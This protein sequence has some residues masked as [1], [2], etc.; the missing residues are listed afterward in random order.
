MKQLGIILI[1]VLWLSVAAHGQLGNP[2]KIF[3]GG[4]V[5]FTNS[6]AN[7][8]GALAGGATTNVNAI[9]SL[10]GCNQIAVQ[11]IVS[12]TAAT[13]SNSTLTFD[14]SNDEV[15]WSTATAKILLASTGTVAANCVSNWT[16]GAVRYYR[17]AS[18]ANGAASSTTSSPTVYVNK[19]LGL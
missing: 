1:A 8:A 5:A 6:A 15:N 9:I 4:T 18:I 11:C 14:S 10:E 12:N 17:L 16:V 19:K 2:A 3:D 7:G 13:T